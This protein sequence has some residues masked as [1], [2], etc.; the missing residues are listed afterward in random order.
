MSKRIDKQANRQVNN[1]ANG[2]AGKQGT[3]QSSGVA[4]SGA[5]C[6][7]ILPLLSLY[8]DNCLDTP[9]RER[10]AAHL[11]TC[12]GC[13]D[14]FSA[15]EAVTAAIQALPEVEAASNFT[16]Q[17]AARV[18]EREKRQYNWFIK[19]SLVYSF[20]FIIFCILGILV[21]PHLQR[22][23]STATGADAALVADYAGLDSYS[24]LLAESQQLGLIEVQASSIEMVYNG[25][26]TGNDAGNENGNVNGNVN[27]NGF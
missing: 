16:A 19:P 9:N 22:P 21:N 13:R 11:K 6:H 17:V 10:V 2:Q 3:A 14:E 1:Q 7:T 26:T 8:Q 24:D 20:V 18:K 12:P 4:H 15:L 5:D 25:N 23:P 27:G